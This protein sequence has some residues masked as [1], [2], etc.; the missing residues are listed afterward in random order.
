MLCSHWA[1]LFR[2]ISSNRFVYLY[3]WRDVCGNYGL[4]YVYV[5]TVKLSSFLAMMGWTI[6]LLQGLFT[7][8]LV[9]DISSSTNS[10]SNPVKRMLWWTFGLTLCTL[11]RSIYMLAGF[12]VTN[13]AGWLGNVLEL[14][15]CSLRRF[16]VCFVSVWLL[17]WFRSSALLIPVFG[18]VDIVNCSTL[19]AVRYRASREWWRGLVLLELIEG[20]KVNCCSWNC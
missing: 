20:N 19:S 7:R 15:S 8:N 4:C 17:L 9:E 16:V 14:A 1:L 13:S 5:F 3:I 11:Q 2:K 6:Y 18:N 10:T 12:G